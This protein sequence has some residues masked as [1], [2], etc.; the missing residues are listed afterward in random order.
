MHL[1]PV[2]AE[3]AGDDDD[4]DDAEDDS[5]DRA[6]SDETEIPGDPADL[7]GL[8]TEQTDDMAN[9]FAEYQRVGHYE[10]VQEQ[11]RRR[12]RPKKRRKQQHQHQASEEPEEEVVESDRGDEDRAPY[13]NSETTLCADGSGSRSAQVH[14]PTSQGLM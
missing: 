11:R 1:G 2:G 13:Q 6:D 10:Y 9:I 7:T 4:E 12:R 3:V 14:A 8:D 5:E